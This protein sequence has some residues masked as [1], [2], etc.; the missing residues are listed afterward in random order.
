[1]SLEPWYWGLTSPEL[2]IRTFLAS[3]L[4]GLLLVLLALDNRQPPGGTSW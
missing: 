2:L 4:G 1:M 3:V